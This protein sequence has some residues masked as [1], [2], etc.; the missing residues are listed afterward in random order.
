MSSHGK[1]RDSG[2]TNNGIS[3]S[4]VP[5]SYRDLICHNIHDQ[6]LTL[7]KW[8]VLRANRIQPLTYLEI[9]SITAPQK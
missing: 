6:A 4:A 7:D 1:M 2:C 9:D 8:A 5:T 3:E